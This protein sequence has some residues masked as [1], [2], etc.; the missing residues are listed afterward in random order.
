MGGSPGPA[1]RC[2]ALSHLVNDHQPDLVPYGDN[3]A[4]VVRVEVNS[5]PQRLSVVVLNRGH[6]LR[7][8]KSIVHLSGDQVD[9]L[10]VKVDA[11]QLQRV[12]P[13]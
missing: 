8:I 6:M 9:E 11:D 7:T 1:I 10:T 2:C 3:R 5:D 12:V 4:H 13:L